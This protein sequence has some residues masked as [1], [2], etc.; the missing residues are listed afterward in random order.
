MPF[1]ESIPERKF[2]QESQGSWIGHRVRPVDVSKPYR[3]L[4]D[5][6]CNSRGNCLKVHPFSISP[7]LANNQYGRW[8]LGTGYRGPKRN[9]RHR[10]SSKTRVPTLQ[11]RKDRKGWMAGI[12]MYFRMFS[13]PVKQMKTEH[14]NAVSLRLHVGSYSCR[15]FQSIEVNECPSR[16]E[17]VSSSSRLT[18]ILTQAYG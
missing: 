17:M 8:V 15:F 18:K 10:W 5:S 13:G 9:S 12:E 2:V 1:L 3:L 4:L 14:Q 16:N 7:N 11:S 6:V